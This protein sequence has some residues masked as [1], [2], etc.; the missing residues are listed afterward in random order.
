[1]L[2]L[3]ACADPEDTASDAEKEPAFQPAEGRWNGGDYVV[4]E[5]SCGLFEGAG[6]TELD[7]YTLSLDDGGFN[8]DVTVDEVSVSWD[9]SLDGQD[10]DC[11]EQLILYEDLSSQGADATLTGMA[12]VEGSFSSTT[13]ASFQVHATVSCTG[14][15][16]DLAAT[17]AG[18]SLP[19]S[20]TVSQPAT[21]E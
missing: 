3:I 21:H 5:D 4:E 16:C 6:S 9:C 20:A 17:L 11:P 7:V 10:F 8:L 14:E 13:S 19:C 12:G 2:F 1:M 15:D 18:V